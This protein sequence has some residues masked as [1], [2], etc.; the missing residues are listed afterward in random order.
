MTQPTI[1]NKQ[2]EILKL[3]YKFR[4]LNTTHFQNIFKHKDPHRVKAWL[5]DLRER[6]YIK[7]NYKRG[8]FIENTKPATYYLGPNGMRLLQ[9]GKEME[10]TLLDKVCQ[11]K[12]RG[13]KFINHCLTLVDIYLFFLSQKKDNE[14]IKFFTQ[15]TL[16]SYDYFPDPLPNG[17]IAVKTDKGTKRYF[18][19]L[20]D[21]YTPPFVLRNKVKV[22]LSYAQSGN[23]EANS[24]DE[25]LPMVLF[26]CPSEK[27]KTHISFYAKALFQKAYEEKVSLFLTTIEKINIS[28]KGS[29][30]EKVAI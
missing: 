28:N 17:Y 4:F 14:Q 9:E 6:K 5:K 20:F 26:I 1:T 11:E 25:K 19:D 30:W 10:D 7:T 12:R 2:I 18:L 27:M 23:W 24:N 15:S 29:I 13:E 21:S 8:S 16:S 22:Y 3:L